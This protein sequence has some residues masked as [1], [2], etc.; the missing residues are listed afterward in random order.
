MRR[1]LVGLALGRRTPDALGALLVAAGR[2][3]HPVAIDSSAGPL[4]AVVAIGPEVDRL[5]PHLPLA[6]W[7]RSPGEIDSAAGERARAIV[8]DV[9]SIV[10]AAA[11]R[12]VLATA[13]RA[14]GTARPMLPFVRE[15]LRR[16]RGLDPRAV[17]AETSTGWTWTGLE[18]PVRRELVPTAMACAAAVAVAAPTS[19]LAALAW[20][21]PSVSDR[22][23]A[24]EVGAVAG[25]HVLVGDTEEERS[26]LAFTLA[27]DQALAAGLSWAGRRLVEQRH[28][29]DWG[30]LRL[31]ELLAI[32]PAAERCPTDWPR[33]QL[34]SL[35]A[36]EDGH[37]DRRLS[38]AVA[39]VDRASLAECD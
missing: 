23:S 25:T 33:L 28:D 5:A 16:A 38:E 35:G 12:G 19:L 32:R 2:W 4:D 8:S 37:V 10:D 9:T 18:C 17:L 6:L 30:A 36:A 22:Q 15:R 11:R 39:G 27:E 3:C 14:A 13:E 26:R 29:S 24:A 1:A 31:M 34:A 21:A 7:T 20:G